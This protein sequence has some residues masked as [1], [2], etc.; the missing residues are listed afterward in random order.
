[1]VTFI[2]NQQSEEND[3]SEEIQVSPV[4]DLQGTQCRVVL[5]GLKQYKEAVKS[6]ELLDPM[7]YYEMTPTDDCRI[8][9]LNDGNIEDFLILIGGGDFVNAANGASLE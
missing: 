5:N 9:V 8:G 3:F 2:T 7:D 6:G 1:M 4:F